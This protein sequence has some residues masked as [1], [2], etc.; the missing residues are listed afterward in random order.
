[1]IGWQTEINSTALS[2]VRVSY[3]RHN[4][5]KHYY[6]P[7][8]GNT[9]QCPSEPSVCTSAGLHLQLLP[10]AWLGSGGLGRV[11]RSARWGHFPTA[12]CNAA[13]IAAAANLSQNGINLLDLNAKNTITFKISLPLLQCRIIQCCRPKL[14]TFPSGSSSRAALQ[15]PPPQ[16]L[17]QSAYMKERGFISLP[18]SSQGLMLCNRSTRALRRSR[19]QGS[20]E[21]RGAQLTA[22]REPS[23]PTSAQAAQL[24]DTRSP[25]GSSAA[26]H[27]LASCRAHSAPLCWE[28]GNA[29][30]KPFRVFRE[31][32]CLSAKG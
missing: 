30:Q 25:P 28:A 19:S 6:T 11:Q 20:A 5:P 31:N 29:G 14:E 13:E 9:T 2:P 16:C 7:T 8:K 24:P 23:L 17:F 27:A 18:L 15:L 32:L 3:H 4:A 21:H 1:M 10:T 22:H 26:P 12:P